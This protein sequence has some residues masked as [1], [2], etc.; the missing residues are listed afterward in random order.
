MNIKKPKKTYKDKGKKILLS[1]NK[2]SNNLDKL[3]KQI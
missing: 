1:L 3:K 2:L